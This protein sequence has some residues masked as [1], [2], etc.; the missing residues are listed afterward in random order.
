MG[1]TGQIVRVKCV[2]CGGGYRNHLVLASKEVNWGEPEVGILGGDTYE[3]VKCEG[4]EEHR[5]R[6]RHWDSDSN[7]DENGE[8]EELIKVYPQDAAAERATK[9]TLGDELPEKVY[10]IYK[11]TISAFNAGAFTL[12]GAGLRAIVEA[13]CIEQGVKGRNLDEKIKELVTKKLLAEPQAELLHEERYL[14]NTAVHELEAPSKGE[15]EDGLQIIEGLLHTLYILPTHAKRM[16]KKREQKAA[17]K[18]KKA[19]AKAKS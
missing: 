10:D 4:C 19:G 11:E 5:F 16:K 6:H 15:L 18:I 17:A 8:P 9:F 7:L 1:S 12:C 14:G 2:A 13:L 3:I